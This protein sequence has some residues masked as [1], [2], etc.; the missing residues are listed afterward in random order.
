MKEK[1][2][3]QFVLFSLEFNT[4]NGWILQVLHLD[5]N[6]PNID[7][8]LFGVNVCEDFMYVDLFYFNIKVFDKTE[9]K[10]E[11]CPLCGGKGE[12][13]GFDE[14]DIRPCHHPCHEE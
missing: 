6:K 1:I 4:W 12:V 13:A 11:D 7:S 3:N 14:E 8:S 9:I 10:E 2:L 5:L